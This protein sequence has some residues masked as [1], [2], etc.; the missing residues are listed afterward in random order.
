MEYIHILHSWV[1][2]EGSTSEQ[3]WFQNLVQFETFKCIWLFKV[4]KVLFQRRQINMQPVKVFAQT[5]HEPLGEKTAK[6]LS[7]KAK[8][9]FFGSVYM[10]L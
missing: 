10:N 5:T 7:H 1:T 9:H 3:K 6:K 4:Q 8:K 2:T